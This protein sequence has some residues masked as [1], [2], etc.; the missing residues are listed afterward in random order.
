MSP[1]NHR[2]AVTSFVLMVSAIGFLIG[3]VLLVTKEPTDYSEST[4]I[5][6]ATR[7][8]F[9][10]RA[11]ETTYIKRESLVE[12]EYSRKGCKKDVYDHRRCDEVSRTTP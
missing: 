11:T 10:D 7:E 1:R 2:I 3:P 12:E 9:G 5:V 8:I 6:E 4:L